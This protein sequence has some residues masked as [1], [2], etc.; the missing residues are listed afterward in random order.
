[1]R[2]WKHEKVN[3]IQ[4]DAI[5]SVFFMQIIPFDL[6][7]ASYLPIELNKLAKYILFSTDDECNGI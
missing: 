5:D 7:N 1:M 2:V 3:L 4:K 6:Q